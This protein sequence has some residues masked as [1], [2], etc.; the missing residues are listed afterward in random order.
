MEALRWTKLPDDDIDEFLGDG[1]TGVISFATGDDDPPFTV[2]VSYGY[3]DDERRFYFRLSAPDE[4]TKAE[5]LDQ[6]VAFVVHDRVDGRW[7][8]VVATGRL[9]D[10]GDAPYDSTRVQGLWAVEIP[11]VEIFDRPRSDVSFRDFMLDP[12][13]LS[14]RREFQEQ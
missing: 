6:P 13:I 4:G 7:H 5:F 11:N 8:S 12:E 14:G 2:P 9:D 3:Y 1:G 10:L